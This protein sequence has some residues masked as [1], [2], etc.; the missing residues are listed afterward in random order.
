MHC[1]S[2]NNIDN[3]EQSQTERKKYTFTAPRDYSTL[4]D[5]NS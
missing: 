5:E 1:T 2:V 3:N 4:D